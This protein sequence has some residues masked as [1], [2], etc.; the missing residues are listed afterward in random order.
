MPDLIDII[1]QAKIQAF[2][3]GPVNIFVIIAKA[4][5]PWLKIPAG[6]LVGSMQ[7]RALLEM[8]CQVKHAID[9]AQ[10]QFRA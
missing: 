9:T 6:F 2:I 7:H 8:P 10:V 1:R 3:Q 5:F 4:G